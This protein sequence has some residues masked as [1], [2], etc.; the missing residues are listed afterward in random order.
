MTSREPIKAHLIGARI[1]GLIA[2]LTLQQC[3][4]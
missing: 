3:Q 2:S 1:L 4:E